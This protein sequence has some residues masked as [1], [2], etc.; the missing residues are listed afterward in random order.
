[1]L[2]ETLN[3]GSIIQVIGPVLDIKFP[4]DSIP[5]IYNAIRIDIDNGNFIITEVQQLLGDNKVRTVSMQ[6]G[7]AHV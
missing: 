2:N 1:M 7:R 6:I 5:P 3:K 4:S